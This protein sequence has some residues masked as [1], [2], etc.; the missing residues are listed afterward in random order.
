MKK[1]CT[2]MTQQG[3]WKEVTKEEIVKN[4]TPPLKGSGNRDLEESYN[5]QASSSPS[6]PPHAPNRDFLTAGHHLI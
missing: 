2:E 4:P 3:N 5:C 6:F 1:A